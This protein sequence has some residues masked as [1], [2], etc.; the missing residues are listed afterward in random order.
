MLLFFKKNCL[1]LLPVY[2]LTQVLL[3]FLLDGDRSVKA[4]SDSS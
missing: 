3:T 2:L 1:D 4:R